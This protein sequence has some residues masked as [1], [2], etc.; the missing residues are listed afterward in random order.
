MQTLFKQG[1][2]MATKKAAPKKIA[3]KK[4]TTASK[5][6]KKSVVKSFRLARPQS[7]FLTIAITRQTLYWGI[8]AVAVLFLGLWII[9][10]QNKV[11]EIYDAIDATTI[12]NSITPIKKKN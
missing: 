9:H 10:L 3:V 11:N 4:K 6:R 1:S 5:A 2:F 7:P 8:I 12:D